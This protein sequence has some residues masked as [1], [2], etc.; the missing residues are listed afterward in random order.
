MNL[1]RLL[2]AL[3]LVPALLLAA[4][5][6]EATDYVRKTALLTIAG[7]ANANGTL[8]IV[9]VPRGADSTAV[10]IFQANQPYD[11]IA[12]GALPTTAAQIRDGIVP[13]LQAAAPAGYTVTAVGPSDIKIEST[14][15]AAQF[16]FDVFAAIPFKKV[17]PP[18]EVYQRNGITVMGVDKDK[19][20][21]ASTAGLIL[22]AVLMGAAGVAVMRKQALS[23]D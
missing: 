15:K 2:P 21:G 19:V 12:G 4:A 9:V 22:V 18:V 20:P 8:F 14:N 6:S 17:I 7:S 16:D 5:P 13:A 1:R 3:A 23:T 11:G 10:P